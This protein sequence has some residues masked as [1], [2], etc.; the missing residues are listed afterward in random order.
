MLCLQAPPFPPHPLRSLP[1][2][3][4]AIPLPPYSSYQDGLF[5]PGPGELPLLKE[6]HPSVGIDGYKALDLSGLT[7]LTSLVVDNCEW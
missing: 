6:L 1:P 2:S 7:S 4:S 3:S 5:H